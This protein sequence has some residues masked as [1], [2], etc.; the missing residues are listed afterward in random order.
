M[1]ATRSPTFSVVFPAERTGLKVIRT[2]EQQVDRKE[3]D[4]A[5]GHTV[6]PHA[7][8]NLASGLIATP[9]DAHAVVADAWPGGPGAGP[10][11]DLATSAIAVIA[12]S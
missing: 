12:W 10:A 6:L 11:R 1:R 4:R 3:L 5:G 2:L 8:Q 9:H 7:P